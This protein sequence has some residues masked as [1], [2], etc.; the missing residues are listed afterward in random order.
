MGKQW[1]HY[2]DSIHAVRRTPFH[3]CELSSS[4]DKLHQGLG[5]AESSLA[6]Q[7]R[8]EKI[9][10]V[11][12][13]HARRVPDVFSPACQCGWRRQDPKHVVI[14]CLERAYNRQNLYETAG[15]N[16]YDETMSTGKGL[17]AVAG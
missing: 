17:R 1:K 16:K 15:A 5:K 11:A 9:G 13:L 8:T 4:R 7:L 12:F 3:S 2:L 10:L 14:F 6:I